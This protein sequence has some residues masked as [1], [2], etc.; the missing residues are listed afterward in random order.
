MS[1][2]MEKLSRRNSCKYCYYACLCE[3]NAF[4]GLNPGIVLESLKNSLRGRLTN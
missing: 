4:L 1:D 3:I 2:I